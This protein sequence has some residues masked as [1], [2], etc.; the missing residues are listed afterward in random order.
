VKLGSTALFLLLTAEPALSATCPAP[1][2]RVSDFQVGD[3][4]LDR[5]Y[6]GGVSF[7]D[8]DGD[9]DL[10]IFATHGYDVTAPKYAPR[11]SMLYIN[12]GK[13]N[14]SRAEDSALSVAD[15]PA[16]GSTWADIDGDGDLDAF[17]S[18]ELGAL[19]AFYRNL[20]GGRFERQELGDA[21]KTKGGNFTSTWVDID[22]DGDQDLHV[23]GPTLEL[24][25]PML[26][27]RNDAGT[28]VR[29]TGSPL[30]GEPNNPG[31]VLWADVDNDGDLDLLVANSDAMRQSDLQPA[32]L[33]HAVLYRNEGNWRFTATP[34]QAFADNAFPAVAAAFG[35]VDNDGDLDLL[36]G[37]Y[38]NGKVAKQDRLFLNDGKGRFSEQT[39]VVL[40]GHLEQQYAL[41]FAD[42]NLDGNLDIVSAS[43]NDE[44]RIFA[45]N[46]KG[47]FEPVEDP[48]LKRKRAYSSV[49]TGD[50]NGDG[51][52]D[53]VIGS[54]AETSDG[55]TM[56]LLTNQSK[57]CG[58]WTE[59]VLRDARGAPNP[60]GARVTLVT[61]SR[62]GAVR[63]QLREASAQTGFRS[64]SASAFLF[65]VPES[66]T[67]AA[68]EI[69]W[70]NGRLQRL[71][72]VKLDRRN[73]IR[74]KN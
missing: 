19:D 49:A 11:R 17:V 27:Y 57:P 28:F 63:R 47:H 52:P 72:A 54:W 26:V 60:P 2:F 23:G 7:A 42:F 1:Q 69:R 10:D 39:E 66:E 3:G 65:G 38:G 74:E 8:I 50:L 15:K 6:P 9:G 55:D 20:G 34:G 4:E 12:D 61:R 32:P 37:L 70:P 44:I 51:S 16:S 73:E 29:V 64:Q 21:T 67:I 71:T 40:P 33:E 62:N 35:D 48:N 36:L 41:A 59:I 30:N 68:A 58:A 45:G 22:H 14:F 18:T 56:T 43:Y 46:G 25:E 31:A 53:A 24:P 5:G 13:E